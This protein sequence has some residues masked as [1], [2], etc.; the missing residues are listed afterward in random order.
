MKRLFYLAYYFKELDRVKLAKFTQHVK[1]VKNNYTLSLW[2]DIVLSSLKYNISILDYFYFKFYELDASQRKTF[3][4]TGFMYEYQLKMNPKKYRDVLENKILF[5]EKYKDFVIRNWA[6]INVI[7]NDREKLDNILN[8]SSGKVVVKGSKGQVGAE[9]KILKSKDYTHQSLLEYMKVNKFDLLEEYVV[10]HPDI[11]RLSPSGLNTVR[12]FTQIEN[13]KL[14]YLGARLRITINSQIDNMAAGNPAAPINIEAGVVD[15]AGVFS[16]MAVKEVELHPVT[17]ISIVGFKIPF[18]EDV[19]RLVEQA[20]F[21]VPENKSIGWDIA[22]SDKGPELIEGN[23]N[24]CKLL[25]QLPVK[26][27]MKAELEKYL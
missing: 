16:D 9:V 3:A 13:G 25:W 7:E 22:I 26:K 14:Y 5:L 12:I 8:N 24:W 23:H 27:G 18:W 19:L 20:V 11:M 2:T 6:S 10:Q 15:G 1:S 4:G 17:G 21:L